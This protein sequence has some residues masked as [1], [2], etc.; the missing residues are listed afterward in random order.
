MKRTAR[1]QLTVLQ[2]GTCAEGS[3]ELGSCYVLSWGEDFLVVDLGPGSVASLLDRSFDLDRL[4]AVFLTHLHPDHSLEVPLLVQLLTYGRAHARTRPL[5]VF[6]GPGTGRA[7]EAWAGIFG[8]FVAGSARC[9]VEVVE[10]SAGD[11]VALDFME[12]GRT[13]PAAVGVSEVSHTDSS[14]A[15]RFEVDGASVVLT[16]DTGPWDP[17]VR[18]AAGADLLVT[19]CS[20]PDE[21]PVDG[22]MTPRAVADLASAARVGSVL[23][24]HFYPGTDPEAARRTVAGAHGGPVRLAEPGLTLDVGSGTEKR[25][26]H[27]TV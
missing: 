1:L 23:L 25:P 17:L 10:L 4:A 18:F 19:E 15:Y 8:S 22:H 14:V 11:L 24:G 20:F 27:V 3:A 5:R 12:T 16:G 7:V 6:G 13:G 26:D 21:R 9:P 2:A